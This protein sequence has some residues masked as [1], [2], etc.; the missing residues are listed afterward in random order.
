MITAYGFATWVNH[1]FANAKP[2][3]NYKNKGPVHH[4]VPENARD[5]TDPP[6]VNL[7]EA[8]KMM[9]KNYPGE[10]VETRLNKIK[11]S[12]ITHAPLHTD[13]YY[14]SVQRDFTKADE[15]KK[16]ITDM[17]LR[18]YRIVLSGMDQILDPFGI[19]R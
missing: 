16:H 8:R 18:A 1:V 2:T 15:G 9:D 12:A 17:K 13:A 6:K 14:E 5:K 4:I 3:Y 10:G 11:L 19:G 7:H